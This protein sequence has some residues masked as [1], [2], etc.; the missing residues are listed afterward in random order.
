MAKKAFLPA[1]EGEAC[2]AVTV[3]DKTL[4][5]TRED[6][7]SKK[8]YKARAS[9]LEGRVSP[10]RYQHILGVADTAESLAYTYGVNPKIARLA[11]LLHDWDKA[12]DDDGIRQRAKDLNLQVSDFVMQNAPQLLHG[13]TA[14]LY[15][16]RQYP[17]IP[18]E[19]LRSIRLHTSGAV[20]MTPLD[21]VVYVADAIEPN[22]PYAWCEDIRK[23]VGVATL[24]ELFVDTL[25][26]VIQ[27][28]VIKR[29][30]IGPETAEVW[31]HYIALLKREER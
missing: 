26:H 4:G 16:G 24:E 7:L 13:P 2:A 19:V 14:A 31:N 1:Q 29:K 21:M 3:H 12:Y 11:G 18:E 25:A 17:G 5:L 6:A 8:F 28:L 22:R 9:E 15:L 23:K 20:D 10:K 30:S 27:F